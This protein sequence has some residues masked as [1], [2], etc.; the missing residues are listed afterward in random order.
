[1]VAE[2]LQIPPERISMTPADSLV[3]P[4][5][6]GPVG[7][8]GTYAIG[9]A[10]INAAEDAKRQILELGARKLGTAPEDL[11]TADGVI[12][13]KGH[14]EKNVKWRAMG[15]DRTILGYGR[16][17][18]DFT[19]CNC[20]MSFVEVEVDTETGKVDL[21]RVVNA[22]DV[23]QIIDPPGLEGQLNGCFGSAG[24]DSAIFEETFLSAGQDIL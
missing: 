6:F 1:M 8:R 24:I 10:V 23:G 18:P 4:F 5:E 2:V 17:D 11:D 19:M 21:I 9:S 16:F 12:F 13:V 7:S 14:P 20:M 3:T 22:T 15:N